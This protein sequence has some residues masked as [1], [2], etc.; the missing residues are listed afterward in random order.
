[1]KVTAINSQL[2]PLD[3]FLLLGCV[4]SSAASIY[5]CGYLT[6]MPIITSILAK[7]TGPRVGAHYHPNSFDDEY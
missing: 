5:R 3:F 6:A 2:N 4:E 7:T 1:M